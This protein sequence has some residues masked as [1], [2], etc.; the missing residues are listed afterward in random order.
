MLPRLAL[1]L[2]LT[3]ACSLAA[4][5]D[6]V[7]FDEALHGDASNDRFL[8]TRVTLSAGVQLIRGSMGA[9]SVPDVHDL[10]YVT[11]EVPV[12][13]QLTALTLRNARVGG[14]FSFLGIQAG[15]MITIPADWTS[16]NTPLLGW[17]HFGTSSIGMDLLP[18]IGRAPGTTGFEGPLGAGTYALWIMELRDDEAFPYEFALQVTPVPAPATL[19][20]ALGV[21]RTR[22]RRAESRSSVASRSTLRA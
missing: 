12:G 7:A 3:H 11:V 2:M 14:A 22:R 13:H 1:A 17:T 10:D 15:P 6:V 18:E 20:L 9:T 21:F 5:A 8:P 19:A 4:R 16:I